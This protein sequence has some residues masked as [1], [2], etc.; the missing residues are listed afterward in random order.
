M[1]LPA[2]NKG[3]FEA[4]ICS[5]TPKAKTMVAIIKEGR[6]PSLSPTGAANSEPKKVPAE[7]IDTIWDDCD[8]ETF[9]SPV[10]GST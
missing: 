2:V 4:L 3:I 7:R 1:H 9:D 10:S 6:R 8:G 5:V